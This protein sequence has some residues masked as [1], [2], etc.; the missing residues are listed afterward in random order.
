M[1]GRPD[2]RTKDI[3]LPL[4]M[5]TSVKDVDTSTRTVVQYYS[6]WEQDSIGDRIM[7]GAWTKTIQ[8]RGPDSAHP[9]IK[10]CECHMFWPPLAAPKSL[11]QDD[12]GLLATWSPPDTEK[13]RDILVLYESGAITEGSVAF[14]IPKGKS[15]GN[16]TDRGL[17]IHEAILW[18]VSPVTWGMN[19]DTPV[20]AIK[21]IDSPQDL[22]RIS[23]EMQAAQ[24]ALR[25]GV[26][27]TDE[28]PTMLALQIDVWA[29]ALDEYALAQQE[30]LRT[31]VDV[32][33]QLTDDDI[34]P[35]MHS[36]ARCTP[37]IEA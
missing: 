24:S 21:S 19:A 22:L 2:V 17:D 37:Q 16:E 9:R 26:W 29:K 14:D 3:I 1:N 12:K 31:H 23:R 35:L 27:D 28:T 20:V 4:G 8:E 6:S 32:E 10:V 5:S 33:P 18:E 11:V 7:P 36:I 13:G 25:N 34:E 30:P 15:E